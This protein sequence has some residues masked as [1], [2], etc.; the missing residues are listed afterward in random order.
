[1]SFIASAPWNRKL[2]GAERRYRNVGK[3]LISIAVLYSVKFCQSYAVELHALSEA[4]DFY[5][6]IGMKETG[7]TKGNLKEFRLEK[8][9]SL[10]LARLTLPQ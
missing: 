4:E 8:P 6:R 10:A 7:R 5:R 2:E 3:I 9:G 1:M